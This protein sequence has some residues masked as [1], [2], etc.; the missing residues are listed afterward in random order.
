ML[1]VTVNTKDFIRV[2]DTAVKQLKLNKDKE[3]KKFSDWQQ[4]KKK[5]IFFRYF[6]DVDNGDYA[7]IMK[8]IT[9]RPLEV[10]IDK[11]ETSKNYAELSVLDTITIT[12]KELYYFYLYK[13]EST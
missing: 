1:S 4:E 5:N 11:L 8:N 10:L 3:F 12:D 9:Y 6:I 13:K 7:M 2:I